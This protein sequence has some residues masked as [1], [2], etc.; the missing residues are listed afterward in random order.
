[1]TFYDRVMRAGARL[2]FGLAMVLLII[3]LFDA[4]VAL[5][6][7]VQVSSQEFGQRISY[8]NLIAKLV[9]ALVW[10][11]LLLAMAMIIDRLDRADREGGRK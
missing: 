3:Q 1:M 8:I 10:P 5:G 6:T 11:T 2:I 9:E 7:A 4:I